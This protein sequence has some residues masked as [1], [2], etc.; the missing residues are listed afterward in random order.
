MVGGKSYTKRA[1][2]E[3]TETAWMDPQGREPAGSS[4]IKAA[5][6]VKMAEKVTN[7]RWEEQFP[8]KN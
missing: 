6:L 2:F 5:L 1:G 3:N 7:H 4:V 8:A